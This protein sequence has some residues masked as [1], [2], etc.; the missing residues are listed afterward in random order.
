MVTSLVTAAVQCCWGG[1]KGGRASEG[2]Q[3]ENQ[4]VR[5]APT[6]P[7]LVRRDGLVAGGDGRERK[8]VLFFKYEL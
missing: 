1:Q 2:Q 4:C 6:G 8:V 5:P 3:G 7:W